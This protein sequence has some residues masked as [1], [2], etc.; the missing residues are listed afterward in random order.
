MGEE[1]PGSEPQVFAL[2]VVSSNRFEHG[3]V[4]FSPDGTEAFWESSFMPDET[5]YSHGRILTS[6]LG[7]DGWTTPEYASFSPDF[8]NGGDVPFFSPDGRRLYFDSARPVDGRRAERIWVVDRTSEGW[9][10]PYLI[11]GGPNTMGMHWQFS[12]AANGNIYIGSGDPG[13]FGASDIWVS[14]LVD[15]V[16]Q[17]PENLGP[18]INSEASENSPF[19]APDESYLIFTG[20]D[21]PVTQGGI[22]LYISFKTLEGQWTDAMNMGPTVNGPSYEMC[23]MVSGDGRYLFFNSRP[24][25]NA[26]NY[27]MDAGIID[28]LR[29]Q[30][31]GGKP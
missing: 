10:E 7:A 1:P 24:Q 22:D 27:W 28:E 5:G 18:M 26:D 17:G 21:R 29:A 31:L 6:R 20:M 8:E 15:G 12:V 4:T 11:Q 25:G 9:S 16:Y 14:R 13:G 19:I 23:P 3:T 30:A 2:D